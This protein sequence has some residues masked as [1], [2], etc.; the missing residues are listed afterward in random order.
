MRQTL[1]SAALLLLLA[2]MATAQAA[3]GKREPV[4]GLPCEGCDAVFEGM[5]ASIPSR[6]R[7]AP[8][9]VPG[10]PMLVT[11]RVL[12]AAGKPRPGVVVYAYQTD[13]GGLYPNRDARRR[14]ATRHGTL[15]GWARSD[16]AGRYAF[17]TIRPAGYPGTDIPQHIHM[18]VI[19]PGCATYYIDDIVFRDDPRLDATALRQ[20]DRGRGG[21]GV[22]TP[23]L[24]EGRWHVARDIVLGRNVPGHKACAA[25]RSR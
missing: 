17:D 25:P 12:D 2:T 22:A 4:V 5:P 16:A 8:A 11:G 9:G 6:G 10:E 7:I 19:E 20:H 13:A 3:A 15:R 21:S 18:H 1:T 23:A 24:R 14:A